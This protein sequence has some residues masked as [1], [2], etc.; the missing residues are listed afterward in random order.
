[1]KRDFEI[2]GE[3]DFYLVAPLQGIKVLA[4]KNN[5]SVISS[6]KLIYTDEK[7]GDKMINMSSIEDI[8]IGVTI[9]KDV[10]VL[11]FLEKLLQ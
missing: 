11:L 1:M 4:E 8:E 9:S 10:D 6:G 2:K 5:I 3:L 7:R